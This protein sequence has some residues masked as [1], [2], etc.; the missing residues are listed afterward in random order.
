MIT[1]GL[2]ILPL[3]WDL[4]NSPPEQMSRPHVTQPWYDNDAGA[5]G[6][7][8]GICQHIDNL[9]VQGPRGDISWG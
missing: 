6:T 9:M 7:F 8:A 2:G 3:I 1:Y 4:Q 5:G